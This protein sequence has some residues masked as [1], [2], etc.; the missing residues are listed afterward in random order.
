MPF[1]TTRPS[2]QC[3]RMELTTGNVDMH[4]ANVTIEVDSAGHEI[5]QHVSNGTRVGDQS[6]N[7]KQVREA[8]AF[9]EVVSLELQSKQDSFSETDENFTFYAKAIEKCSS[10]KIRWENFLDEKEA[11][12]SRASRRTRINQCTTK[13][14]QRLTT[15][16]ARP[17]QSTS[18]GNTT[19]TR[20]PR[21]NSSSRTR[22]Q[23]TS[24]PPRFRRS[25]TPSRVPPTQTTSSPNYKSC[26]RRKTLRTTSSSAAASSC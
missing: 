6:V 3:Y 15:T 7:G 5:F 26:P 12:A 8:I 14:H 13:R 21:L 24:P 9:L 19:R 16:S 10:Y 18:Q 2:S 23:P 25:W 1:L 22:T 17:P 4:F 20:W 11:R